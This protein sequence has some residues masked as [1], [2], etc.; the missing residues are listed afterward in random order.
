MAPLRRLFRKNLL[1]TLLRAGL[2]VALALLFRHFS[3]QEADSP[4]LLHLSPQEQA[5]LHEHPVLRVSSTPSYPPYDFVDQGSPSGYSTDLVRLLADKLGMQ[6]DFVPGAGW[7]DLLDRFCAGQID[8]LHAADQSDK[9]VE[10]GLLSPPQ[11]RDRRMF[12]TQTY[13]GPVQRLEDLFGKTFVVPRGWS[14]LE[15]IRSAHGNRFHYRLVE[16][17]EQALEEIRHGRADFTVASENV[18]RYVI[19]KHGY[20]NIRPTGSYEKNDGSDNLYIATRKDRPVLQAL[21]A[22]ALASVTS[23]ER[24]ALQLKW[25]G[26]QDTAM[27][28]LT[29]EEQA[30]LARKGP[31]HYCIDPLWMPIDYINEAGQHDGVGA[32]FLQ[33]M[34]RILGQHLT[35]V[36]TANWQETL[37]RARNGDC[38]LVSLIQNTP[39]YL[40]FLQF[41]RPYL[42]KQIVLTTRQDAAYIDNFTL[43]KGQRIGV[44]AGSAVAGLVRA[45]IG[46][47]SLVEFK[48]VREG[49]QALEAGQLFGFADITPV[50]AYHINHFG[51]GLKISGD[52]GDQ[53]DLS[54]GVR[55]DDHLLLSIVQKA[56]DAIDPV[57]ADDLA[58]AY[59]NLV[60][61]EVVVDYQVVWQILFVSAFLLL[62]LTY[63]HHQ[64]LRLKNDY[65]QFIDTISHE[66]RTPLA[67][68][69]THIDILHLQAEIDEETFEQMGQEMQRLQQLFSESLTL[70]RMGVPARPRL[71][72]LEF[73]ELLEMCLDE[74]VYR[75]PDCPI[76]YVPPKGPVPVHGDARQL[77]V[78]LRNILSN[79]A[80]YRAPKQSGTLV[81]IRLEADAHQLTLR[82]CNPLQ[83]RLAEDLQQLFVRFVRGSTR[84]GESGMGLGLSLSRAII[85]AHDGSIALRQASDLCFCVTV[86]MP[87]L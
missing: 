73:T 29:G 69:R 2:V 84:A 66:Y 10:C 87:C 18:L 33:E 28:V 26:A 74:L 23:A 72:P 67:S 57:K 24:Q 36:P 64:T 65:R 27:P 83:A 75:H 3:S 37:M 51:L 48:S 34:Q 60:K 4:V 54:L 1:A 49:L 32:Q 55:H 81:T 21:I 40:P 50:V 77:T 25:F 58:N 68:L 11:I 19:L 80:K 46:S 12:A 31:L 70:E 16:N 59:S 35:L 53:L 15:E 63:R 9:V 52:L 85:L 20:G 13:T 61:T 41:T 8:L 7:D 62:F 17:I 30:H 71:K 22:K 5:Y 47:A 14:Q 82:V 6:I 42:S 38:D 39:E 79:A 78:A 76:D 43:L 56:L 86:R 45:R 44:V